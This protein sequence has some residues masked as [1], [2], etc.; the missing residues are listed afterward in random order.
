LILTNGPCANAT[1]TDATV[2]DPPGKNAAI[3]Y[4]AGPCVVAGSVTVSVPP[5]DTCKVPGEPGPISI[6]EILLLQPVGRCVVQLT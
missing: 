3:L 4:V 1:V 6:V 2:T 5:P